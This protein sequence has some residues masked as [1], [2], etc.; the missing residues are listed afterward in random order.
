MKKWMTV[1]A[2]VSLALLVTGCACMQKPEPAPAPAPAPAAKPAPAAAPATGVNHVIRDYCGVGCG[3]IRI[4]KLM[5]EKVQ[6]N[7]P[8][9]YTITVTNLTD[10]MLSDI[11]VKENLPAGFKYKSSS[12]EGKLDGS[13]LTWSMASLGPKAM[14]K[15]VVSGSAAEVGWIQTCANATYV[16]PACTK[17]QVVQPAL[18]LVKTAPE[19]VLLCDAIPL[20]FTVTNK[21]TGTAANVK[22]TDTLPAG[23]KTADGKAAVEMM[24]GNIAPGQSV[25]RSVTVKAE[26]TGAYKNQA[27]AMAD[28]DLKAESA[29]TETLVTQPVLAIEKTGPKNEY[30]GRT[31]SYEI[32]VANK[33]DAVAA[34]TVVIDTIPA[35]VSDVVVSDSGQVAAGRVTWSLG[36]MAPGANRKL[37]VSYKPAGAGEFKNEASATA[38]CAAG[39][40]ASAATQIAGIPAVLLEV[41]DVDDP[42]E[43][44]KNETYIITVTNQGTAPD[45][46]IAIKAMLEEEME[47]VS[48]GGATAGGMVEGAVA[49]EALPSLA[50]GAKATWRVV[51][52]AVKP[53]DVRLKV[54]MST[55][56]LKREV[57]ETEATRFFE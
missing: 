20:T 26:K 47:F 44:G 21:G 6:L 43:V 56:E 16:I 38:V 2:C 17:T 30:L 31:V 40:A 12:P 23:L 53:G 1:L 46:N 24:L 54:V 39:V 41:I 25:T 9:D 50:P 35:N 18:A 3:A 10:M 37:S 33:G 27:F 34:D 5:P 36:A 13:T 8:F 45:T 15:I 11:V 4:E 19:K 7:Q 51:V 22:L 29:V 32:M 55:G 28:G 49:F 57:M 14:E 42:I 52:K 48:A